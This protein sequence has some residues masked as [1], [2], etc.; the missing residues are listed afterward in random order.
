MRLRSANESHFHPWEISILLWAQAR[1]YLTASEGSQYLEFVDAAVDELSRCVDQARDLQEIGVGGQEQANIAWSL[2]IL[3][4]TMPPKSA[5]LLARIFYESSRTCEK[6]GAIQLEHAHQLWQ[7]IFVLQ[8]DTPEAVKDVPAWFRDYLQEIWHVEKTRKKKSSARHKALSQTLNLM[9]V[10]HRNEHD[11]DID[12]AIIL[13]NDA[14]WTHESHDGVSN[15]AKLVAVEF[16]GP[17]HFTRPV[18][19]ASGKSMTPRALGHT[20]LKYRLLK[21]QGW[22][23]VRVPY[24]EFDKIPFWSSMERQRYLQRLLKTHGNVRFS[25]ADYSEYK[26]PPLSKRSR[27]D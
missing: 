5:S 25:S 26:A 16:D 12:V 14:S 3:Q 27:F 11:E 2:T 20:V 17:N 19:E 9:G 18:I 1:L 24:Y 23:V 7:A 10:A 22:T 4:E 15:D 6:E 8:E 21:K 13:K